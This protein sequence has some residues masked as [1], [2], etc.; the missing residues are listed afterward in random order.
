MGIKAVFFSLIIFERFIKMIKYVVQWQ[1]RFKPLPQEVADIYDSERYDT[2][3]RYHKDYVPIF[4]A[5]IVI[6]CI[7]DILII[8][9]G[10]LPWIESLT[11]GNV[12]SIYFL[13][14]GSMVVLDNLSKLPF[15]YYDTFFIE[16]KYGLNKKTK[17]NS[18]K[19]IS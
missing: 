4:I 10:F 6:R 5:N 14:L 15:D 16:E 8:F 1:Y 17:K 13:T 9:G 11:N 19:I 12:Y 3:I 7:L 2:Y 18:S